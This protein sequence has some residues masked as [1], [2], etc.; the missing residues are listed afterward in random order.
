MIPRDS[1]SLEKLEAEMDIILIQ[2]GGG[3]GTCIHM[4]PLIDEK[5][6][7]DPDPEYCS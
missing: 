1:L 5:F 4:H 6:L 2:G 3:G 7:G